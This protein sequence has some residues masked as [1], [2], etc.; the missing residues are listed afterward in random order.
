MKQTK[1]ADFVMS[2]RTIL[3]LAIA[4][5]PALRAEDV[6][7]LGPEL[8]EDALQ[9]IVAWSNSLQQFAISFT[10]STRLL[11]DPDVDPDYLRISTC[12]HRLQGKDYY[13]QFSLESAP[14]VDNIVCF[15]R[16]NGMVS[17]R[18]D[19]PEANGTVKRTGFTY[20][21]RTGV[22]PGGTFDIRELFG[23]RFD[24]P[25]EKTLSEGSSA[26][27]QINGRRVLWHRNELRSVN[28]WLDDTNR[29]STLEWVERPGGLEV[30]AW[31]TGRWD[32]HLFFLARKRESFELDKYHELNGVTFPLWAMRTRWTENSNEVEALRAKCLANEISVQ[33]Y[34]FILRHTPPSYAFSIAYLELDAASVRVNEP[35]T[36]AD[37]TLEF[38]EGSIVTDY[39]TGETE[40]LA[41]MGW[42]QELPRWAVVLAVIGVFAGGAILARTLHHRKRRSHR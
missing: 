41:S 15:A 19:I 25:L 10:M 14:G 31:A 9:N 21:S 7:D 20:G 6:I 17:H 4:I 27:L 12:E 28:I 8:T 39:R 5:T 22:P 29:V 1:S 33:E 35:L 23:F 37:F 40:I 16:Y 13:V 18:A 11:A 36:K 42:F 26:L 30:D 3:V 34:Y 38:P 32:E 2:V 24:E